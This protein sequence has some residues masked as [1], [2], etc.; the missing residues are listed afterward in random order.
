VQLKYAFCHD[1]PWRA[2]WTEV[3][4]SCA[5][6]SCPQNQQYRWV[7]L[8][9]SRQMPKCTTSM[10]RT[11]LQSSLPNV[12]FYFFYGAASATSDKKF[13][14]RCSIATLK[15]TTATFKIT[16]A[17]FQKHIKT[18]RSLDSMIENSHYNMT[19]CFM[20]YPMR[21]TIRRN[22]VIYNIDTYYLQTLKIIITYCWSTIATFQKIVFF[23]KNK[24]NR[25][26]RLD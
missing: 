11:L 14:I 19:L 6:S 1:I 5:K 23:L 21:M 8:R 7:Q 16:I 15:L 24:I 20:Q 4:L 2:A 18:T 9:Q 13:F 10:V 17:I 12:F 26:S 3:S 25:I 22:R